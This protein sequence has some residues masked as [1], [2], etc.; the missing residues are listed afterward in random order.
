MLNSDEYI[1]PK[2]AIIVDGDGQVI[3]TISN[4]VINVFTVSHINEKMSVEVTNLPV[5]PGRINDIEHAHIVLHNLIK[6]VEIPF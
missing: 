2:I 1:Q 6:D 3:E 5:S 4:V